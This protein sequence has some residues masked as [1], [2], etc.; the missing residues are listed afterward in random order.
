MKYNRSNIT[1][2]KTRV[3]E[4]KEI[5]S[6]FKFYHVVSKQNPSDL[7]TRGANYEDIIKSKLWF[8]GPEWLM[9]HN[10]LPKKG[11][12]YSQ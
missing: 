4:K 8:Y 2:V 11:I 5:A 6:D 9:E 10:N 7:L 3:A 1:Y 12:I